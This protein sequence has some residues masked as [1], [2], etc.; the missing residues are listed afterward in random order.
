[1]LRHFRPAQEKEIRKTQ[2][3]LWCPEPQ[4]GIRTTPLTLDRGTA[5]V[6][7]VEIMIVSSFATREC[8]PS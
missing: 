8:L 2:K 6:D 3:E 5:A 1:M 7:S 4:F